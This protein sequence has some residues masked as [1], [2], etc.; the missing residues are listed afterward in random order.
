MNRSILAADE[1]FLPLKRGDF[2]RRGNERATTFFLVERRLFT[3]E[4]EEEG[5]KY[6]KV[7]LVDT[8]NCEWNW[9]VTNC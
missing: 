3:F 2:F 1:G 6:I 5:A 9:G 4:R 8:F 7:I